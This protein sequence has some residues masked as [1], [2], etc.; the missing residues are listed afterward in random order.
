MNCY[1]MDIPTLRHK[2]TFPSAQGF[3][4]SS[5]SYQAIT[6]GPNATL[7]LQG[8][9]DNLSIYQFMVQLFLYSSQKI[10]IFSY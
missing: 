6:D 7:C 1:L 10:S 8:P 4:Q 2:I 9:T 5:K 3:F